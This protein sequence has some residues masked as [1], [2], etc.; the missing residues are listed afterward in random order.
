M[1]AQ[2]T[3]FIIFLLL[4]Y[5]GIVYHKIV[6]HSLIYANKKMFFMMGGVKNGLLWGYLGEDEK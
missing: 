5:H 6:Y 3:S 2:S 1:H 4:F